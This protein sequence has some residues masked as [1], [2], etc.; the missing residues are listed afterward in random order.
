MNKYFVKCKHCGAV[1]ENNEKLLKGH[2]ERHEGNY[3]DVAA[4]GESKE[5][6]L[7]DFKSI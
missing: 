1:L 3:K 2:I 5:R 6:I 4:S 7:V